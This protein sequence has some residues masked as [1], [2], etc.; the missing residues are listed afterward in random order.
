MHPSPLLDLTIGVAFVSVDGRRADDLRMIEQ[1]V[2]DVA[3]TVAVTMRVLRDVPL[4]LAGRERFDAFVDL[5]RGF[6]RFHDVRLDLG[7]CIGELLDAL[8]RPDGAVS[9]ATRASELEIDD[10]TDRISGVTP[11]PVCTGARV[12]LSPKAG[13]SFTERAGV[14]VAFAPCGQLGTGIAWTPAAVSVVVPPS[15]RSGPVYFVRPDQEAQGDLP[16]A[17]ASEIAAVLGNCPF[18]AGGAATSI[19]TTALR[20]PLFNARCFLPLGIGVAVTIKAAPEIA[21][22]RAVSQSG[23]EITSQ[24]LP[25]PTD[26]F[27]LEWEVRA[28]AAT[29]PT[30]SL[31]VDGAP[32]AQSLPLRGTYRVAAAQSTKTYRLSVSSGCG[33]LAR[34]LIV[35]VLRVLRFDP[36]DVSIDQGQSVTLNLT[37]DRA[38]PIATTVMLTTLP[39]LQSAPGW[40]TLGAGQTQAQVTFAGVPTGRPG[41]PGLTVIAYALRHASATAQI[42]ITPPK[43]TSEVVADRTGSQG[44]AAVDVVGVHAALT[45]SG[46]VLLFAYDEAP[47]RYYELNTGKSVLW[48]PSANRAQSIPMSRNLFCAG[49]AFLGDGRLLV[50]GGQSTAITVGGWLGSR[51]GIGRGADHDVHDFAGG[52][53]TRRLPDMPGARWY[54]TCTTLPDGR[55]LIVSGYAA[56][57]YCTLNTDYEIFDGATNLLARRASFTALLPFNHEFDLYPF[58]QVLPGGNL[59][60]HSHDTTWLLE[61][62]ASNEPVIS[63]IGY[64]PYYNAKSPNSRTYPGQGACVMLPLDPSNAAKARILV[65]GG[66][67]ALHGSIT[68]TTPATTTAEI[69]EFDASLA[70][71][72]QSQ[73]RFTRDGAGNQTVLS[74]PRLMGDAVLLPDATVAI[75]GGAGGGRADHAWPPVMWVESFDTASETFTQRTPTSVPRL[76]HSSA[77]LLPDGSVMIAGSTGWRWDQSISGGSDN[78]FRI[79][80][81]QPPYMFRGPRPWLRLATRLLRYGQSLAIEVP[82]GAKKITNAALLRHGST[83]HTNN[84]DQRY[85]G[86]TIT[87]STDTELR[88]ALPPDG[89]VAPPGPYLLFVISRDAHGDPVPSVG[90]SVIL[91][92]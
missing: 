86:L 7:G 39:T 53:W 34:D 66:G 70:L 78:E 4:D 83:T 35:Q 43:G 57:A 1:S 87:N 65:V 26:A 63:G 47:D 2:L 37:V 73:W 89:A 90:V 41:G 18:L 3:R 31:L 42:W 45:A 32:L 27:T 82:S 85:V 55:V 36:A 77:L 20:E 92:A 79:E 60:V 22:F 69:F 75:V 68:P 71:D 16:G 54:P 10:N 40:V 29:S 6:D 51:F 84:M 44:R 23:A 52:S 8:G 21:L 49:H 11:D 56:H 74:T 81:Y 58:I 64:T 76:Y 33:M 48:D 5:L 88:V 25:G 14:T 28:D 38:S 91:G 17:A 61:L 24:S 13:Q 50:A 19:M 59:F 46:E 30:V 80:R 9:R 62:N 12:T 15:A 72:G 67:G